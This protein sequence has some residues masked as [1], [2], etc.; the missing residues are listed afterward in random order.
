VTGKLSSTMLMRYF[1]LISIFSFCAAQTHTAHKRAGYKGANIIKADHED[2]GKQ[3]NM[4]HLTH[5]P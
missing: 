2:S 1:W 5:N 4:L 3:D